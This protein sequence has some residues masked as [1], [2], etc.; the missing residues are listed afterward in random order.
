MAY[1]KTLTWLA[2]SV[3]AFWLSAPSATG[4]EKKPDTWEPVRFLVGEWQGTAKGEAGDG[5]VQRT[6]SFVLKDRYL[7][8]KNVSTYPPQAANKA[9]EVHEHWSFLSYDRARATIVLRQ[10]HQEGFVNQYSL[11]KSASGPKKLVFES[12]GFENL[13]S[14]WKARETYEILSPDN[15]VETFEIAAPGKE[16]QVY[17][18]NSFKRVKP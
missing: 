4:Q 11:N 5:T 12:E 18:R 17:S 14:N 7:H 8:E 9:G 6:Y 1:R 3:F 10:F 13:D 15:F 2:L 16:F